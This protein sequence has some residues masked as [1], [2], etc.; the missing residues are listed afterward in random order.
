[1]T[2]IITRLY[3]DTATARGVVSALLAKGHDQDT[4]DVIS[5]DGVGTVA[6]RMHAASVN[7]TAAAAYGE[8]MTGGR[9]LVVVRAPFSPIGT[10]LNAKKVMDRTASIKVGVDESEYVRI[11]PNPAFQSSVQEDHPYYMSNPNRPMSHGHVFGMRQLSAHKERRSAIAGG[12][13]ISTKFWPMKLLSAQKE[14]RS[15]ISGDWYFS[16]FLLG[17]PTITRN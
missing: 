3:A 11:A 14:R 1:M 4:I 12:A 8:A 5:K 13:Y 9:A 10:A 6:E 7:A 15:A 16:K 2:T 17:L